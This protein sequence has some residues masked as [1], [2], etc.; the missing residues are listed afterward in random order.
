MLVRAGLLLTGLLL[1]GLLLTVLRLTG[2]LLTLLGTTK[3]TI[4]SPVLLRTVAS[5][6]GSTGNCTELIDYRATA[7]ITTTTTTA[8]TTPP[9]SRPRDLAGELVAR[10]STC[11]CST[12]A[13]KRPV[14]ALGSCSYSA[15]QTTIAGQRPCD[16]PIHWMGARS[17][18]TRRDRTMTLRVLMTNGSAL[19][20][21]ITSSKC[22]TSAARMWT[23]ASASPVTVQA[24]VTSG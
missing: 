19:I 10:S 9:I 4:P 22:R 14:L 3:R 20:R 17:R 23:R 24:S 16:D 2:L 15:M 5:P 12:N 7:R 11:P 18:S 6:A 13:R 21:S 8:S 1:T